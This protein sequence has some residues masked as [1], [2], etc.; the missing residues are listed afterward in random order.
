MCVP[1]HAHAADSV[2]IHPAIPFALRV[3]IP[4]S[5]A[6]S[7][8][9]KLRAHGTN[10]HSYKGGT[11]NGSHW[12]GISTSWEQF[13]VVTAGQTSFITGKIDSLDGLDLIQIVLRPTSGNTDSILQELTITQL[14]DPTAITLSAYDIHTSSIYTQGYF[15]IQENNQSMWVPLLQSGS[16]LAYVRTKTLQVGFYNQDNTVISEVKPYELS[17]DGPYE[18]ILNPPLKSSHSIKIEGETTLFSGSKATLRASITPTYSGMLE[19]YIDGKKIQSSKDTLF[20]LTQLKPGHKTILVRLTETNESITLPLTIQSYSHV[21]LEKVLPQGEDATAAE[22]IILR[23]TN[24]FSVTI[25]GWQL[26]SKT[27]KTTIPIEGIIA[28]NDILTITTHRSLVNTNGAYDLYDDSNTI[29]D[30][31]LYKKT[32]PAIFL[33]RQGPLWQ[34]EHDGPMSNSKITSTPPPKI[35]TIHGIVVKKDDTYFAIKTDQGIFKL[36]FHIHHQRL[37]IDDSLTITGYFKSTKSGITFHVQGLDKLIRSK[38]AKKPS[39]KS[40]SL[41]AK[42][43][44]PN[45]KPPVNAAIKKIASQEHLVSRA[46]SNNIQTATEQPTSQLKFL[47]ASMITLGVSLVTSGRK[48]FVA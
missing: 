22:Q 33:I 46:I 34:S 25:H 36:L 29:V 3:T 8:H 6:G 19:W 21:R 30:T 10:D 14:A 44:D 32:Y 15:L 2:T 20:P 43:H 18:I 39:T 35:E 41:V 13:P 38:T 12:L 1:H 31:L 5:P 37:H 40:K 17:G 42:F 26:R 27:S 9:I 7:F 48:F 4:T 45:F 11:W 47:F 16:A 28:A 23:N 24:P